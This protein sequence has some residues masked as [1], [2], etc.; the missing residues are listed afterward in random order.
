MVS[1]NLSIVAQVY[2]CQVLSLFYL[3]FELSYSSFVCHCKLIFMFMILCLFVVLLS[4]VVLR[5]VAT[6]CICSQAITVP[7]VC[8]ITPIVMKMTIVFLIYTPTFMLN[9]N[10]FSKMGYDLKLKCNHFRIHETTVTLY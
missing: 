7:I 6:C 10:A 1:K 5:G 9:S 4:C 8:L 2:F 3:L